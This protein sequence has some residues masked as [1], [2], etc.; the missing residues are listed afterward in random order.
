MTAERDAA[1][2][3]M[4]TGERGAYVRGMANAYSDVFASFNFDYENGPIDPELSAV[5][6]RLGDQWRAQ[7]AE[8]KAKGILP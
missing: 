6:H 5:F 3:R 7:V 4:S 2:E 1:L 8:F